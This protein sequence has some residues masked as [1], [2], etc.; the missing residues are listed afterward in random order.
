MHLFDEKQSERRKKN[1]IPHSNVLISNAQATA[2]RLSIRL[3]TQRTAQQ[4]QQTHKYVDSRDNYFNNQL[5]F[6]SPIP[7]QFT[8]CRSRSQFHWLANKQPRIMMS[9][10]KAIDPFDIWINMHASNSSSNHILKY[11]TALCAVVVFLAPLRIVN[12]IDKR[13]DVNID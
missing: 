13:V 8:S 2:S 1:W 9:S 6:L 11:N 4:Q 7:S 10:V 5:F 12:L 3:D